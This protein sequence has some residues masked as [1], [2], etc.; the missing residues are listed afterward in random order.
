MLG[1]E[2]SVESVQEDQPGGAV[3]FDVSE[4]D[5]EEKVIRASM[6]KPVIAYFSAPW[7]GPCKQLRPVL[8]S[9]VSA[10][11]GRVI[12]A[13]IN[14]DES[15]RLA[16]ALRIQSVPTVFAFFGG[17]PLDAFQGALPEKKVK[18]FLG[19][20]MGL[21]RQAQPDALDIP[22]ALKMAGQALAAGDVQTAHGIYTR[23]LS[24]ER[25][26]AQ[27]YAGLVRT[28]IAA[29][30]LEQAAELAGNAPED[31]QSSAAF[32]EA[33]TAL[34]LAQAKPKTSPEKLAKKL[35]KNPDDLQLRFDL[36]LAEFASGYKA[37]AIDNLIEII[38]RN[39]EWNEEAARKQLLKFFE[40]LGSADPL[41]VAGRKKLSALLFS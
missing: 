22:E 37:R 40:A 12:M 15:Q 36:A 27:A 32:E 18:A 24:E 34:E 28:F 10:E 25:S 8:E 35:E 21:A 38:Q 29:G 26:N 2:N 39:R 20:V 30:Q 9:A 31:I 5:F 11:G 41:T 14:M 13:R 3:I 7:C 17:K 4:A 23:I 1:A 6:E 19:K 33:K 16:V